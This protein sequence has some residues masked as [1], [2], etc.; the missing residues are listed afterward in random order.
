[1]TPRARTPRQRTQDARG[2]LEDDTDAWVAT[3]D[4][5]GTPWPVPLS[6][7]WD[8]ITWLVATPSSSPTSRN[9]LGH[10]TRRRTSGAEVW[11]DSSRPDEGCCPR[12]GL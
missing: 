5:E 10:P 7:L 4:R 12:R 1:M 3:A 8:G 9:L 2:R 6:F 11:T